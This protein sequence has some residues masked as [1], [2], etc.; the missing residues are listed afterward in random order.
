NDE[1]PKSE[2]AE[3]ISIDAEGKDLEMGETSTMAARE[4]SVTGLSS[5]KFWMPMRGVPVHHL[6]HRGGQLLASRGSFRASKP[7]EEQSLE[8]FI[9]HSP[10]EKRRNS[11]R[12]FGRQ[13]ALA[14][15]EMRR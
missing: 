5:T 4:S 3:E 13:L 1:C 7:L 9:T 15:P 8:M 14:I 10:P 12:R 11:F 2:L 6:L